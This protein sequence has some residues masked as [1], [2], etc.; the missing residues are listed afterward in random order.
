MLYNFDNVKMQ[1]K[2]NH[3]CFFSTP[4]FIRKINENKSPI[5]YNESNAKFSFLEYSRK[6]I[7]K[8]NDQ[9]LRIYRVCNLIIPNYYY[10]YFIS[11]INKRR[12]NYTDLLIT[13]FLKYIFY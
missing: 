10:Q 7:R 5:V 4:Y 11:E 8:K 3:F 9:L 2:C 13:S 1:M 12:A 6:K